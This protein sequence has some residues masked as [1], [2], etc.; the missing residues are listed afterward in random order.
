MRAWNHRVKPK[1]NDE[2]DYRDGDPYCNHCHIFK[3]I[4]I[5][6]KILLYRLHIYLVVLNH[7]NFD[8]RPRVNDALK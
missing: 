2:A 1:K 4:M 3:L 7:D 8:F 5:I 6:S